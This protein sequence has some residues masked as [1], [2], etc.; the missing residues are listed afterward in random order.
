MA[1][2]V[3]GAPGVSYPQRT[4]LN[5]QP[6]R[7]ATGQPYGVAGQQ[8]AAQQAVPVPQERQLPTPL[9]APSS[10]PG[11]P[12]TAGAPF[13]P[14]RNAPRIRAQVPQPVVPGSRQDVLL[15]LQEAYRLYPSDDLLDMITAEMLR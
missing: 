3:Q 1:G 10:R 13:G 4:D 11:E 14:G 15:T 7:A 12:I 6:V 5:A 2:P 8:R 9:S